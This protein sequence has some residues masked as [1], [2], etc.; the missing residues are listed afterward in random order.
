MKKIFTVLFLMMIVSFNSVWASSASSLKR[1]I[2][3]IEREIK[4]DNRKISEIKSSSK[5]SQYE[6]KRQI[7]KLENKIYRNKRE[8]QKIKSDYRRAIS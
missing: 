8:L 5:L 6:K 7:K 4:Q 1:E 2:Y 3:S